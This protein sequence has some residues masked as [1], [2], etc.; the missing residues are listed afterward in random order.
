VWR[1][2][3]NRHQERGY[4]SGNQEQ[5]ERGRG[6]LHRLRGEEEKRDYYEGSLVDSVDFQRGYGELEITIRPQPNSQDLFGSFVT[7]AVL[8]GVSLKLTYNMFY[9][10]KTNNH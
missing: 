3:G 8:Q 9:N 1:H 6:F 7:A 4:Q 10:K 2:P 5:G